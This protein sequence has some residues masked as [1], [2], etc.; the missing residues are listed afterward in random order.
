[1]GMHADGD[2]DGLADRLHRLGNLVRQRPAVGVAQ[3]DPVRAGAHRGLEA[4]Q[5]IGRVAL[6]A[7]EEVLG[8][9]ARLHAVRLD[10]VNGV[11]D[12]LEVL[13]EGRAQDVGHV[14]VPGLADDGGDGGADFHEIPHPGIV[15]GSGIGAAGHAEDDELGMRQ[16]L[17]PHAGEELHVGLVSGRREPALDV[18]HAKGVQPVGDLDLIVGGEGNPFRLRTIA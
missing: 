18:V 14:Q 9:E 4:F 17:L 10:E 15:L 13:V 2:L 1:M 8:V 6:P 5:R 3:A 7:V 11:L 16:R 12:Q